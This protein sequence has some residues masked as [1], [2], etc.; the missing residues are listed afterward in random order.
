M[1]H[2]AERKN[3][4][5]GSESGVHDDAVMG[6]VDVID[7]EGCVNDDCGKGV[8]EGLFGCMWL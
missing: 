5:D 6:V 1:P 8:E 3:D 7:E 2:K 4:E